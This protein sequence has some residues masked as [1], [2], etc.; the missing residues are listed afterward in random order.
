[1]CVVYD[2]KCFISI[3]ILFDAAML[4]SM[5]VKENEINISRYVEN[6]PEPK[7]PTQIKLG[8]KFS[9]DLTVT[10]TTHNCQNRLL[11]TVG[12]K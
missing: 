1:M 12:Q 9:Q 5:R 10:K 7:E 3:K 6:N 2:V 11:G 4:F 8:I